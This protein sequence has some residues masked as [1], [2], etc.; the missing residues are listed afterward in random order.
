MSSGD[1]GGGDEY[2][3]WTDLNSIHNFHT[4]WAILT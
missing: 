1:V 2:R 4:N 3:L